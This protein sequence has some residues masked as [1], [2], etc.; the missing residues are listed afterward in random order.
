MGLLD[1]MKTADTNSEVLE[2]LRSQQS[3][4]GRY[5]QRLVEV[6]EALNRLAAQ[7]AQTPQGLESKLSALDRMLS[8]VQQNLQQKPQPQPNDTGGLEPVQ[9]RLS[10]IE[11]TLELLSETLSGEGLRV[12][13]QELAK[14]TRTASSDSKAAAAAAQRVEAQAA[15]LTSAAKKMRGEAVEAVKA[16]TVAASKTAQKHYDTY[17]TAKARR[18]KELTT[19]AERLEAKQLWTAAGAFA[20]ALMP[21]AAVFLGAVVIVAGVLWSWEI[22]T[23]AAEDYGTVRRLVAII[24]AIFFSLGALFGLLWSWRWAADTMEGWRTQKK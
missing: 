15:E 1:E 24:M 19:A 3:Q 16:A 17:E 22:G 2:T 21:L 13:T 8:N 4:M 5:E 7:T 18:V 12:A 20:L 11:K 10:E 9:S 23:A 14:V 6:T